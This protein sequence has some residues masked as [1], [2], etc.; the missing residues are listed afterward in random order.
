MELKESIRF[1]WSH[2]G[3]IDT[4]SQHKSLVKAINTIAISLNKK[5]I[6]EYVETESI[7]NSLRDINISYAQG[8]YY[9]KPKPSP[10]F[11]MNKSRPF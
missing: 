1:E 11:K 7:C 2:L 6:A 8:Y 5:I 4:N 3:N 10:N 9:S